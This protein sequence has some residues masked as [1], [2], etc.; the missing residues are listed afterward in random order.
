MKKDMI[1]KFDD[2][3]ERQPREGRSSE[4]RFKRIS[5]L[6]GKECESALIEFFVKKPPV[7]TGGLYHYTTIDVAEKNIAG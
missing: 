7:H 4:A 2:F 1:D 6:N 5:S 3:V